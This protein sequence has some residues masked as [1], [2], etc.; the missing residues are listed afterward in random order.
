[1]DIQ[2]EDDLTA[3]HLEQFSLVLSTSD[4]DVVLEPAIGAIFI[5]DNDG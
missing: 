2:I 3:E 1:M 4:A 5:Q